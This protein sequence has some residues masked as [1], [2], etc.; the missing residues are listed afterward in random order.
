MTDRIPTNTEA[1]VLVDYET[2]FAYYDPERWC[3][4]Y[5]YREERGNR[6]A[7]DDARKPTS[8]EQDAIASCKRDGWIKTGY[9][10]QITPSG[11]AALSRWKQ[12]NDAKESKP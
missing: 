10:Q 12:K 5:A 9:I 3:Y 4:M 8:R 7:G 1:S 11:R 6:C 2:L